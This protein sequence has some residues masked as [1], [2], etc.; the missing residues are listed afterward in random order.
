LIKVVIVDDTRLFREGIKNILD[1]STDIEVTGLAENGRE[2]LKLCE[3]LLPDVV[4]MDIVMPVM[5][6]IEGT[7]K[8]KEQFN[9]IKIL[10]LTTS[11]DDDKI[12]RA[13]AEG[14]DGYILKDITS[15]ELILSIKSVVTGKLN[16]IDGNIY[17]RVMEHITSVNNM[18]KEKASLDEYNFTD[19]EMS[20]L[21]LVAK[22]YRNREIAESLFIAEGRVKNIITGLLQKLELKDRTQ[23]AVFSVKKGLI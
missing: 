19:K 9:S 18:E 4:L 20:I 14:A 11:S 15:D 7:R 6:G 8:I 21:K 10:M 1:E 17:Q 13:M 5:D 23:L 16:I 3:K 22:G 2:A 12:I